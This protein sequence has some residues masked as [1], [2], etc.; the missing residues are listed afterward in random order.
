MTELVHML[1]G[2]EDKL[3]VA[4]N[5]FENYGITVEAYDF[6]IPEIQAET[7][8]EIARFAVRAAHDATGLAF[9]REDHSF[10]IDE[11]GIPGPYMS[12]MDK[13]V[14]VEKLL[15]IMSVLPSR[16]AH[17]ELAA[18]Y[19]NIHGQLLESVFSV[20]IEIAEKA[21]GNERLRWERVMR[22]PE[23]SQTFAELE[24]NRDEIWSQN[25][26]NIA[27]RIVTSNNV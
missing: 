26:K 21:A 9:L 4:R 15:T 11:L 24:T 6:D 23:E 13:K 5:T 25:F 22:F 1:T 14:S 10:Y 8:L 7:S 12:Y 16:S 17:F 20:P 3:R 18:S 2:N 27:Q 19:I